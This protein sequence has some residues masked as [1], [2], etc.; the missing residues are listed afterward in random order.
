MLLT[1]GQ[2]RKDYRGGC[3]GLRQDLPMVNL[4]SLVRRVDLSRT[5]RALNSYS[6]ELARNDYSRMLTARIR[7]NRAMG[8]ERVFGF[9]ASEIPALLWSRGAAGSSKPNGC[10]VA[11]TSETAFVEFLHR[12]RWAT[13]R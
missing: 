12:A 3:G 9:E 10:F 5:L 6:G 1:R 11:D 13:F 7:I 4:F 8:S 2:G